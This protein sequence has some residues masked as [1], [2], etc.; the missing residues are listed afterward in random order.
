[1]D[2]HTAIQ[3][4]RKDGDFISLFLYFQNK[5]GKLEIR[6]YVPRRIMLVVTQFTG[7]LWE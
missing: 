6:Y 2:T 4:Q 5:D 3:I 7:V 1:M